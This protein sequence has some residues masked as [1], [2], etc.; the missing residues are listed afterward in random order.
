MLDLRPVGYVIGLLVSVLGIAMIVPMLVDIAEGRENT[1]NGD[2]YLDALRWQRRSARHMAR[3]LS[4]YQ[5]LSGLSPYL[6][7]SGERQES[8]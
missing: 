1:V 3:S 2:R 4:Y 6:P 8:L 7:A 5:R